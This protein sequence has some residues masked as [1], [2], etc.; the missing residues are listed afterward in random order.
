MSSGRLLPF[1]RQAAER[2]LNGYLP[3]AARAGGFE[4]YIAPAVL[5]NL[6]GLTGAMLLAATA[7]R[8]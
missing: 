2:Q 5:G 4:R 1:V 3:V 8:V 6:A 7:P